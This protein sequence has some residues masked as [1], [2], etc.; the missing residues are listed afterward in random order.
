[1][2]KQGVNSYY[3]EP[4]FKWKDVGPTNIKKLCAE[5]NNPTHI[6]GIEKERRYSNRKF[7]A[8]VM[9]LLLLVQMQPFSFVFAED[10]SDAPKA[11][12]SSTEVEKKSVPAPKAEP[13]P[14]PKP[15]PAA[16]PE[17]KEEPAAEPE[18]PEAEESTSSDESQAD[19]ETQDAAD[20][21]VAAEEETPTEEE[22]EE[23]PAQTLTAN[24]GGVT[25]TLKAPEGALPEGSKLKAK[26]VGQK[27]ID[28]VES[29]I[30]ELRDA[31]RKSVV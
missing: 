11:E 30:G 6:S 4:S 7:F 28:A 27:Y 17:V 1:M 8:I 31:D 23:Y 19:E 3:G 21:D 13:K 12:T 25:V 2:K 22:K 16:E 9:A 24:A 29:Q 20:A 26:Q 18:T 10:G 5:W 15:E 14:E